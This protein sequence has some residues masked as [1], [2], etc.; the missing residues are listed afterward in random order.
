MNALEQSELE[1]IQITLK[2][3]SPGGVDLVKMA[4]DGAEKL[5]QLKLQIDADV[6]VLLLTFKPT[7]ST[8]TMFRR[9]WFA[10]WSS[11]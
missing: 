2:L 1:N 10:E 5:I 7:I 8:W 6:L 11:I 4:V 3:R 9:A